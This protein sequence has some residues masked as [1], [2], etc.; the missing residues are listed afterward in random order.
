MSFSHLAR[1]ADTV[2]SRSSSAMR[3]WSVSPGSLWDAPRVMAE[4]QR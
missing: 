4:I 3:S 1:S 2:T